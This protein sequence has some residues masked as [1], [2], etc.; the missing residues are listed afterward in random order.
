MQ[1]IAVQDAN[2]LIDLIKIG[3]LDQCLALPYNFTT[4]NIIIDELIEEQAAVILPHIN[5]GNFIKKRSLCF[6]KGLKSK[7]QSITS[8]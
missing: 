3:L 5:A 8:K 7:E 2:I 4:T 6:F 1:I